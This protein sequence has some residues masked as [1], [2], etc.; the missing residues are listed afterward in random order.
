MIHVLEGHG[1]PVPVTMSTPPTPHQ[2]MC[3]TLNLSPGHMLNPKPLTRSLCGYTHPILA[4]EA[5]APRFNSQRD[6]RRYIERTHKLNFC[7]ICMTSR[8]VHTCPYL[9]ALMS[10]AVLTFHLL[11]VTAIKHHLGLGFRF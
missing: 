6:M 4:E 7:D 10:K 9:S 8:K 2:V 3:K 5:T 11:P 1:E